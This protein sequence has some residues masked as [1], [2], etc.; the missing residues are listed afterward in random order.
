MARNYEMRIFPNRDDLNRGA[1]ERFLEIARES[2]AERRLFCAALS[3]GSTPRPLF[4][5]LAQEEYSWKIPWAASHL[6]QVDERTVPPDHAQSNYR[7][8][9]EALLERTPL[10]AGHFHRMAAEL[11]D[12]QEAARAY[13]T[14]MAE[15]LHPAP[16]TW[17]RFDLVLLG[18]GPDGHTASLFPDTAAL[19]ERELWV[20]PNEVPQL[21]TRRLTLTYPVINAAREAIFFV[22]GEDKAATLRRVLY[23][24][25]PADVLPAQG[26][27]LAEGEVRWYLD[28]AAAKDLP[29]TAL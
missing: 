29:K 28:G 11:P 8:I 25:S 3:G 27:Q 6:F 20:T 15:T 14:E 7:M 22:A 9:R 16:G 4:E 26:V 19:K 1:A 21:Q 18:L 24:S 23:P 17:P 5:L 2:V 12:L 13:S 10:P